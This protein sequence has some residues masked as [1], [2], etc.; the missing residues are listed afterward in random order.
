MKCFSGN[1]INYINIIMHALSYSIN[2]V[3]AKSITYFEVYATGSALKRFRWQIIFVP[4]VF[5]L[6]ESYQYHFFSRPISSQISKNKLK[7]SSSWQK[8]IA[9]NLLPHIILKTWRLNFSFFRYFRMSSGRFDS[10]LWLEVPLIVKQTTKLREPISAEKRLLVTLN[11]LASRDLHISLLF[12]YRIERSTLSSILKETCDP[13]MKLLPLII[14]AYHLLLKTGWRLLR[15][16]KQCG[17]RI[18]CIGWKHIRI[19]CASNTGTLF[20]NYKGLLVLF[21]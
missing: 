11:Y 5:M 21:W 18:R 12:S 7:Q 20:Q 1:T 9:L 4:V 19:Q 16:L 2:R 15:T 8:N 13:F 6:L 17:T 14:F 3:G 10:L